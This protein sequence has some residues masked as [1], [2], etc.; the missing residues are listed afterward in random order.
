M[1]L[2]ARAVRNGEDSPLRVLMVPDLS[3]GNPYQRLLAEALRRRGVDVALARPKRT[4]RFPIVRAWL[5]SGRPQ[6][7]HVHWTHP[8]LGL[9]TERPAR[10]ITGNAAARFDWQLRVLRLLRVRITWTVH[11]VKAHETLE[12]D[13]ER[14]VHRALFRAANS[15]ICHCPAATVTLREVLAVPPSEAA[16]I[17]LIDHGN[18]VGTYG[19]RVPPAVARQALGLPADVKVALFVGSIRGY[20]G[21]LDLVAAFKTIEDS[22]ARLLIAGL[23]RPAGTEAEIRAASAGDERILLRLGFVPDGAIATLMGAADFVVLPFRSVLTSGSAILAMSYGRVVVAPR[24]G[25]LPEL[26]HADGGRLYD[27]S[28]PEALAEAMRAELASDSRSRGERNLVEVQRLSWDA[29]AAATEQAY[30][31]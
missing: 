27:P 13:E 30:R 6:V 21:V 8:L 31:A 15:V 18:Y 25:C 2:F 14:R 10:Q 17:R 20:K 3:S 1:A 19:E 7:V 4:S 26:L 12:T 16:K 9:S 28:Q 24:M 22:T 23:P 5:A 11:N 29:I